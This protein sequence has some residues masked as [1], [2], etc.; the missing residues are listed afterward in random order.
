MESG[1][2]DV[3]NLEE[4]GVGGPEEGSELGASV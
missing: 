2:V 3:G 4:G 1:C